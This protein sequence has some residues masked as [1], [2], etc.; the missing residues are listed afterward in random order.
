MTGESRTFQMRLEIGAEAEHLQAAPERVARGAEAALPLLAGRP[1]LLTGCGT[2]LYAAQL[3]SDYA[4]Q[5]G[6]DVP[7]VS[8]R[9]LLERKGGLDPE[10]TIVAFS[11]A[12]GTPAVLDLLS[13][14]KRQS[15]ATVLVTG[16]P[17]SE[18]AGLATAV[19][20]T[21]YAEERS[22]CHTISFSLS[23]LTALLLLEATAAQGLP[24]GLPMPHPA[25]VASALEELLSREHAVEE[26]AYRLNLGTTYILSSGEALALAAE[27]SL[28][29][30]E[31]AYLPNQ[32]LE[33]EQFFHGYIPATDR[34]STVI[35]VLPPSVGQRARDL[36]A[37]AEIVGFHLLA[38]DLA[39]IQA[40][41]PSTDERSFPWVAATYLQLL[42]YHVARR[43]GTDPDLLRREDPTYLAA[44]KSYR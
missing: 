12:G 19:V 37:V 6:G 2:S 38:L 4:A 33:L 18:A 32:P 43:R 39:A 25:K 35:A 44:R 27:T 22:W 36:H 42:A 31:A 30:T 14:A 9:L 15:V 17:E 40:L 16:F 8:A 24:A 34:S 1:A 29:L 13:E 41:A 5:W 10:R 20:P 21:G 11:H 26:A 28:K 3:V 23:S 7:A